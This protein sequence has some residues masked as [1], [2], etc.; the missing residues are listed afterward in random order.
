MELLDIHLSNKHLI[1]KCQFPNAINELAARQIAAK[2]AL[3]QDF[4]RASKSFAALPCNRPGC[5]T[6]AFLP[7]RTP[8]SRQIYHTMTNP[9]RLPGLCYLDKYTMTKFFYPY[10]E[11]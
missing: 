4:R 7:A 1:L 9:T 8:L 10:T 2:F 6:H 3:Y 5:K 11:T